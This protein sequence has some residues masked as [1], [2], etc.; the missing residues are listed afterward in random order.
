ML[1]QRA[2]WA[3]TYTI[4][5]PFFL[6]HV[7]PISYSLVTL[8]S[9]YKTGLIFNDVAKW[10]VHKK[11]KHC[12]LIISWWLDGFS[13]HFSIHDFRFINNFMVHSF[14]TRWPRSISSSTRKS[15]SFG[16][17]SIRTGICS[18]TVA[19]LDPGSGIV[20]FDHW[21]NSDPGSG[22]NIPDPQHQ[23]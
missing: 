16:D 4:N 20:L 6:L 22:I 18:K 13:I 2:R 10:F 1:T 9:L 7:S 21:K 12:S 23:K 8:V 17:H 14:L 19:D 3:K 5:S 11:A 15:L